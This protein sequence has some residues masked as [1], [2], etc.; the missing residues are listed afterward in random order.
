LIYQ[1]LDALIEDVQSVNPRVT[2]FEDSCFS[3]IYITGG[4]DAGISRWG[5]S[6]A[7]R[8]Q[9]ARASCGNSLDLNLEVVD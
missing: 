6:A 5:R 2:S 8:W 1:D 4:R 7:P 3:G 9:Q